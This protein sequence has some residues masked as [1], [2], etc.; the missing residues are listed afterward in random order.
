MD[1]TVA[2][3]KRLMLVSQTEGRRSNKQVFSV[4]FCV[5]KQRDTFFSLFLYF[6]VD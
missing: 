5:H 1:T 2:V 6:S 4:V 3:D